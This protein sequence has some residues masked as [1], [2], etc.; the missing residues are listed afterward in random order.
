MIL[1]PIFATPLAS[2]DRYVGGLEDV[3]KHANSI[4]QTSNTYN[5]MSVDK[6]V[7]ENENLLN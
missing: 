1:E 6:I 4:E 5:R 3:V 2:L 7:I